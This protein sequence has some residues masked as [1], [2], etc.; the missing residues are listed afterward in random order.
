MIQSTCFTIDSNCYFKITATGGTVGSPIIINGLNSTITIKNS[1]GSDEFKGLFQNGNGSNHGQNNI[2]IKNLKID[3]SGATL[4]E[5][6]GWLCQQ[7]C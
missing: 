2:T 5:S 3:G 1:S 6:G 7:Y 4:V